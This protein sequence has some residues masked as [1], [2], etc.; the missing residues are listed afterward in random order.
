MNNNPNIV[1]INCHDLGQRLG[2]YDKGIETPNLDR[3]ADEGVKFDNYFCTAAQ[4]SPSRG[5]I[6]TGKYPHKHGLIGLAHKRFGWELD[7]SEVTI[8]MF[9]R[10]EGYKTHLFG[11]QHEST[12]P[13]SLG[14]Q[15]IH[16]TGRA[17]QRAKPVA[18]RFIEFL[19]SETQSGNQTPFFA[20]VGFGEPHRPFG[21]ADYDNDDSS[22]VKVPPY[23][24]D[25]PGIRDDIAG[26]NGKIYAV[27]KEVGRIREVLKDTALYENTLLIFTTDHGI[28]MPRAKGTCYDPG[29]ETALLIHKPGEFEGG[30]SYGE[31]LSNVDLL[32]FL[33]EYGEEEIPT[34]IDGRSFLPLLEEDSTYYSRDYLYMEMTWHDQYNPMR[35][36]R[37]NNYKYIK[38]FGERPLVYMPGDVYKGKAGQEMKEEYYATTRPKEELY[39]LS[40]DPLE[41][42]NIAN[43]REDTDILKT[44]RE[45]L[46]NWMAETGDPLFSDPVPPTKAQWVY[47]QEKEID[48]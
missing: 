35:G 1:L 27:D 19:K 11:L 3:M 29:I 20:S 4:C 47:L 21:L 46:K 16:G 24:P 18:N 32:P 37:T 25:K 9:L 45:Q 36:I 2:C 23:L 41:K 43:L 28:A 40:K 12:D 8:P 31:L 34:D 33:L 22:K 5:S 17:E 15:E 30:K 10:K 42:N 13:E 39:N 38:N 48:N 7:E 44:F 26:L 14:Y 6:M